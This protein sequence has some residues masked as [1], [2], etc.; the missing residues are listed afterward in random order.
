M[1]NSIEIEQSVRI[2]Q[3]Q[4]IRSPKTPIYDSVTNSNHSSYYVNMG[5]NGD[6]V[7]RQ[8]GLDPLLRNGSTANQDK[9]SLRWILIYT[10]A[11]ILVGLIIYVAIKT[12]LKHGGEVPEQKIVTSICDE[13]ALPLKHEFRAAKGKIGAILVDTGFNIPKKLHEFG[14]KLDKLELLIEQTLG[15]RIK[16]RVGDGSDPGTSPG[17][18]KSGKKGRERSSVGRQRNLKNEYKFAKY[19]SEQAYQHE[20]QIVW[21][22]ICGGKH[23]DFEDIIS[24]TINHCMDLL[25]DEDKYSEDDLQILSD[26]ADYLAARRRPHQ[27][28]Y[29]LPNDYTPRPEF[30]YWGVERPMYNQTS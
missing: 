18:K 28:W 8:F 4:P 23:H 27:L 11:M 24:A 5:R 21:D 26:L 13:D 22:A 29:D 14:T 16:I 20:G 25:K 1:T 7:R 15:R 6:D 10:G 19:T 30:A 17:A 12:S 9:C 3:L 2:P